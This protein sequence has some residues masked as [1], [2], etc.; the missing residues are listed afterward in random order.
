MKTRC[1]S[2]VSL[3]LTLLGGLALGGLLSPLLSSAQRQG[4]V[5]STTSLGNIPAISDGPGG[6][7]VLHGDRLYVCRLPLVMPS[8]RA[9]EPPTPECGEP[10][11]LR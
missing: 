1:V 9:T 11:T 6:V 4:G 5:G 2:R 10:R 7:W 8:A 3:A